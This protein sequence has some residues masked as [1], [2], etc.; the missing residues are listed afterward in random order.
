MQMKAFKP[1]LET[2]TRSHAMGT[3]QRLAV[4]TSCMIDLA[5]LDFAGAG[6]D[7]ARAVSRRSMPVL[8]Y[9]QESATFETRFPRYRAYYVYALRVMYNNAA[10]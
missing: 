8:V 5:S 10:S 3:C 6:L 4:F 2:F 1:G 7:Y 9:M